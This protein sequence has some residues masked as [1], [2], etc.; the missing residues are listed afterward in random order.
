M[1]QRR[2]VQAKMSPPLTI[3]KC[4]FFIKLK[5]VDGGEVGDEHEVGLGGLFTGTFVWKMTSFARVGE[6]VE[7]LPV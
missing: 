2:T 1:E 7:E 6:F 4:S 3:N 5:I